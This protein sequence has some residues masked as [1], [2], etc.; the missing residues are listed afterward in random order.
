M[1]ENDAPDEQT[2]EQFWELG[3]LADGQTADYAVLLLAYI[4]RD[5]EQRFNWRIVTGS[6]P[7]EGDAV[8]EL[9]G[10]LVTSIK[11]HQVNF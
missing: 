2:R 7:V 6:G 1:N 8:I 11:N 5:G 3:G 4:D 9:L 10:D